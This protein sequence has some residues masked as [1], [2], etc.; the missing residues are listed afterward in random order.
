MGQW[1]RFPRR[2]STTAG[3]PAAGALADS[4]AGLITAL[5]S[6]PE[7]M[8]YAAIAGFSPASGLYTGV[9]PA[10]T[11]SLL[12]R[13]P[14]MITTLTSAIALTSRTALQN[15]RLDPA[16]PAD[17]AALTLT[18]ALAMAA[19]ALLRMGA[20]LRMVSAGAMT[21]FSIGIAVQIVASALDEA[22]GY[23]PHRHNRLLRVLAWA[24]H[25]AGWSAGATAVAAATVL[26]WALA[27]GWRRSRALAVLIALLTAT[28]ATRVAGVPVPVTASLGTIPGGLPA[29]SLPAWHALPRLLAGGCSVAMVALAQAAG[30][31]PTADPRRT[32]TAADTL[33]QAAANLVGAFCHALPAGGS[34]SRTAVSAAA[35]ARTRWAGVASGAALALVLCTAGR[36]AGLIPLPVIGGLLIVI[37]VKLIAHRAGDV[38]AACRAGRRE[39]GLLVVTFLT[40]TELPLPES[41]LLGFLLSTAPEA[42]RVLRRHAPRRYRATPAGSGVSQRAG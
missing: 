22:T 25:P 24:A 10:I 4:A 3:A 27:H 26:A 7:G 36:L 12:C 32:G 28:V 33:A 39:V 16:N 34:L 11:G 40:T 38:R 1:R 29:L 31:G 20:L 23:Q 2:G 14:L 8:A 5:F 9:L 15:A 37:G 19:F 6:V 17:V 42:V 41:L 35:G 21:G 30:I 18:V 13:T